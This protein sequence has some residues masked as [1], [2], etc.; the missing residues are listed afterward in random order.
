MDG[1]YISYWSLSLKA[2]HVFCK[3]RFEVVCLI[4]VY[5][6]VLGKLVKHGY[7]FRILLS[8]GFLI[9]SATQ[10][11]HCVPGR[12]CGILVPHAPQLGLSDPLLR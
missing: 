11:L 8:G 1:P 9:G 3:L 5:H 10:F 6:I 12:P 2:V 4:L 7:H